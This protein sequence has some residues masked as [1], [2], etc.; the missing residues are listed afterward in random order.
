MN[1]AWDTLSASDK[2]QLMRIYIKNGVRDIEVMRTHY[3]LYA[4]GGPTPE[5]ERGGD[6]NESSYYDTGTITETK[7]MSKFAQWKNNHP[8]L[9]NRLRKAGTLGMDLL[10]LHPKLGI[11]DDVYDTLT[12]KP[13]EER[14][15][16]EEL[17]QLGTAVGLSGKM[18][19][20]IY[21]TAFKAINDTEGVN[22]FHKMS[23]ILNVPDFI[24]DAAKFV[25]DFTTPVEEFDGRKR[26]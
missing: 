4:Q 18:L 10:A 5:E 23:R 11:A 13:Y 3:N 2:Q 7:P 21:G 19:D 26:R 9:M 25:N 6:K 22:A 15:P 14:L 12:Q 24:L 8:T 1:K 17:R 16:K 20:A